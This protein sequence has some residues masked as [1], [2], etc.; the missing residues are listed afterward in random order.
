MGP[1]LQAFRDLIKAAASAWV[2]DHAQKLGAA[3]AFYTILAVSPLF[4][5]LFFIAGLW[6]NTTTAREQ[7]FDQVRE[8]IGPQGSQAVQTFLVNPR[9]HAQ[10]PVAGAIAIG[11]LLITAT[12]V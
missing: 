5:I 12:G 7:I 9:Q 3:L 6:L 10:G 4:V 2:S 8:L 11:A 1:R